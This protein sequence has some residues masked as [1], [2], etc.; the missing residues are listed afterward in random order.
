LINDLI[1]FIDSNYPVLVGAENR[2]LAGYSMGG[3][4]T[5]NFGLGHMEKFAW[6]GGFSVGP[7]VKPASQLV[8]NP[9]DTNSKLRLANYQVANF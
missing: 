2:A 1:P 3:G 5:L 9:A 6:I 7:N 4:Q 8:P